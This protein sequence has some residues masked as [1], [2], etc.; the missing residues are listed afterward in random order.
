VRE[1]PA[2]WCIKKFLQAGIKVKAYDPEAMETAESVLKKNIEMSKDEYHAVEN[3]DA[4]VIFTD[5]Q[6]FR[7]PDFDVIKEKLKNPVVF[8][9]RNLYEPVYMRKLGFEYYCIGRP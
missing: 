5:W 8:D 2:I 4:L 3:A 6:Q 9:S 1:S 7:T